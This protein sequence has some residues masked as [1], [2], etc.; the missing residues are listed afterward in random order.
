MYTVAVRRDF[1][2]RHALTGEAPPAERIPHAHAY[3]VECRVSGGR[4]DD[5]GYLLDL[6]R[7]AADLEAAIAGLRD[8]LLNDLEAFRG[9]NPS[10]EH[11]ARVICLRVRASGSI[12][13]GCRLAVTAW[14]SREA[15]AGYAEDG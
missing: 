4:L 12:P 10:L 5:R 3:R 8:R 11:L 14:E 6:D 7:L 2:A 1:S 9:L 15:W 13:P